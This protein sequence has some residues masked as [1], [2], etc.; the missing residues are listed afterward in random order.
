MPGTVAG[1]S[2]GTIPEILQ[3]VLPIVASPQGPL[4][5]KILAY[6]NCQA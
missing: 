4:T 1:I 6:I 3:Q 5:N 2:N